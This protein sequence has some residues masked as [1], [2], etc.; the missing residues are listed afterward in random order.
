[1][2]PQRFARRGGIETRDLDDETF[3]ITR[4]AIEH[5]NPTAARIWQALE[6]PCDRKELYARFRAAYPLVPHQRLN[7]DLGALLR[8]LETKKLIRRL[9]T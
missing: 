4:R 2:K 6:R 8:A 1:M 5:L 3:L 9:K 7:A